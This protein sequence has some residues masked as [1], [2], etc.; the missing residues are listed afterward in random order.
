[1]AVRGTERCAECAKAKSAEAAVCPHCGFNRS[2]PGTSQRRDRLEVS[3]DEAAALLAVNAPPQIGEESF[4]RRF[5]T[6]RG[7][8]G[9]FWVDLALMVLTLPL[10]VGVG[11]LILATWPMRRRVQ[12]RYIESTLVGAFGGVGVL[13]A[14]WELSLT[15]EAFWV[16]CVAWSALAGRVFLRRRRLPQL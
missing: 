5:F 12:W 7:E 16:T 11:I 10:V 1:M 15:T 2:A 9:W 13:L 8:G 6:A 14:G 3:M 4:A